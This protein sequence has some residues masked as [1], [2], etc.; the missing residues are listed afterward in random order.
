VK[1]HVI[2][3]ADDFGLSESVNR[4]VAQG[5]ERGIVTS[6]SL[7]VDRPASVPAAEYAAANSELSVG[8]HL[9]LG[10]WVYEDGEWRCVRRPV[11]PEG[12]EAVTVE[13]ARQLDRFRELTGREPTHIDSHQHVHLTDPARGIVASFGARTGALVRGATPEVNHVGSFYGQTGKGDPLPANISVAGLLG[14]LE[15]VGTITAEVS[16]HPADAPVE[17]SYCRERITELETLCHPRVRQ[18]LTDLDIELC[19]FRTRP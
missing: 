18:A 3:N 1:R 16:C 2:V 9:D 4:G 10:E 15:D 14:I 17:S 5:F 7:M 8:L 11:P 12:P 19:S 6:A 13:V